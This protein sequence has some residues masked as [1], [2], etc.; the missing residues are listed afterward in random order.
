[1][2]VR[3]AIPQDT[4]AILELSKAFFETTD[5][6]H[7]A[8]HDDDVVSHLIDVMR[9]DGVMLVAESEDRLVG[10]VG[11]VVTPFM[12]DHNITAAYEVVWYVDPAA[13]G[14]GAGRLLLEAIEP[15]CV[16]RGADI[17]QMVR[18]S[19]SPEIA[20]QLYERMGYRP[21]EFSY[22]KRVS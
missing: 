16:A 4:P 2:R 22:T 14:A 9:N 3:T 17:I 21:S 5:Y 15:A 10:I 18:L 11:L 8:S 6:R 12:F 1:M 19:T 13:Q 7:F 20:G